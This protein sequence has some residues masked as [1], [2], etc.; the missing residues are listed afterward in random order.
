MVNNA[1][2]VNLKRLINTGKNKGYITY[3]ELNDDLPEDVVSSEYIDDLMMMFEEL[4]IMVIDEASKEEIE[5][6]KKLKKKQ[7]KKKT[8]EPRSPIRAQGSLIP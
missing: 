2:M 3:E 8:S 7:K 4:D 6:S 5:K 1:D